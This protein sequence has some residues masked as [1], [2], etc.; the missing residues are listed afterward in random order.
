MPKHNHYYQLHLV[1]CTLAQNV[2]VMK[3][4]KRSEIKLVIRVQHQAGDYGH[5]KEED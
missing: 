4:G 5:L 2:L 3:T 1:C